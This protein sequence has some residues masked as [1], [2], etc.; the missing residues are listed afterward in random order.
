VARNLSADAWRR[1]RVV[2]Q[3]PDE[4]AAPGPVGADPRLEVMRESI[5]KLNPAL[6]EVLELRLQVELSYDEIAAVLAIPVGTVRSRLHHAVK[7]LRSALT[8][9][10]PEQR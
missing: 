10:K 2:E 1:L 6:R 9:L 7:Q 5:A 3:L 8:R 4:L